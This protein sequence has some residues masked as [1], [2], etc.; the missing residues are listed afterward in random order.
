MKFKLLIILFLICAIIT[1]ASAG[2]LSSYTINSTHLV[3]ISPDI[4]KISNRLTPNYSALPKDVNILQEMDIRYHKWIRNDYYFIAFCGN[5]RQ[6][7][8]N[9]AFE[10]GK[11]NKDDIDYYIIFFEPG[12]KIFFY[13]GT[14]IQMSGFY[15]IKTAQDLFDDSLYVIETRER[16]LANDVRLQVCTNPAEECA[17]LNIPLTLRY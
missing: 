2:T 9:A 1:T 10:I 4:E 13:D 6:D 12:T 14:E 11:I 17:K 8:K 15:K 3:Q 16:S 5:I 7:R